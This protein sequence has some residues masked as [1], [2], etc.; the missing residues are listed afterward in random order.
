MAVIRRIVLDIL[1][2]HEP[3]ILDLA[4]ILGDLPGIEGVNILIYEMDREV[5]NAKITIEG[6]DIPFQQVCQVIID[7]GG[8]VHSLD[9]VVAGKVIIEEAATPQD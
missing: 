9:E 2:P 5:E 6:S 8:A 7:N 1:K 4:S 3:S